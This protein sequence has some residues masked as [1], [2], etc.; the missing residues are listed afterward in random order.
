MNLGLKSRLRLISLYPIL[1]LL[2]LAGFYVYTSFQEYQSAGTLQ[3]KLSENKYLNDLFT[4]ISRER[5]MTVMYMGNHSEATKKSLISQ[6]EIVDE[7]L[8]QLSS[9]L[10]ASDAAK[11]ASDPKQIEE[12]RLAV[13]AGKADFESVY[14]EVYGNILK[15]MLDM[16]GGVTRISEDKALS[17]SASA[18]YNILQAQY[19]TASERDFISYI[20]A[21]STPLETEELNTWLGLIG[22]ADAINY[23]TALSAALKEQ[24]DGLFKDEDNVENLDV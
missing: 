3:S 14:T 8:A 24:L 7:K 1:L 2:A 9:K 22:R 11:L 20:L 13:D 21:R 5:G 10:G 19:Y 15:N 17:A 4:N 12:I 18:Y 6:R 16:L 23:D